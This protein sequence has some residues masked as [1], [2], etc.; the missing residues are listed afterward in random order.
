[1]KETGPEAVPPPASSS[2]D[3]R[4][5]ERFVPVPDPNLKSM[6]SVLASLRIESI[7][8]STELMNQAE[9]VLRD[10]D[11]GGLLRP[12]SWNLDVALLEDN[13]ATLIADNRGTKVPCHF[14][15]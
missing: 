10:H 4:I 14:V 5:G 9:E 11:I 13:L 2:L 8:S 3:D 6:P 7:V 15:E 1:M 12:G